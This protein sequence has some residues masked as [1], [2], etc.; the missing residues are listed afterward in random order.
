MKESY[1]IEGWNDRDSVPSRKGNASLRV[2]ARR[3]HAVPPF[4]RI[5]R[6]R[7]EKRQHGIDS[8]VVDR[9]RARRGCEHRNY[10]YCGR[11]HADDVDARY[12]QQLAVLLKTELDIAARDERADRNARR[13][14]HDTRRDDVRDAPALQQAGE[15]NAARARGAARCCALQA[16]LRA[17]R[18]PS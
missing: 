1:R 18:L 15:M 8:I 17:A 10:V 11:Q 4:D 6:G 16:P 14:L 3:H 12:V 7:R 9:R 2:L 13:C 5:G